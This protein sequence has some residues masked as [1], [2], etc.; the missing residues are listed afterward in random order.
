[1]EKVGSMEKRK[2]RNGK[3]AREGEKGEEEREG[4]KG[5]A[6]GRG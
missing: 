5:M 6:V 2:G 4:E 3:R 1:M